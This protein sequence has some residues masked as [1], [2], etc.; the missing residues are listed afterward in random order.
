MLWSIHIC[1]NKVS[2]HQ[3]HLSES[4][5]QVSTHRS[6]VSFWSYPLTRYWF[7]NDRKLKFNFFKRNSYEIC[8]VYVPHFQ[9]DLRGENSVSCYRQGRVGTSYM[10]IITY[11]NIPIIIVLYTTPYIPLINTIYSYTS[12]Y[13]PIHTIYPYYTPY[14]PIQ[15]HIP[16]YTSIQ[17]HIPLYTPIQH[18]IPLYT[19]YTT[20]YTPI[21][22]YTSP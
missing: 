20:P 15:Q 4:R 1:Q 6:Q 18:H 13:T 12:P 17:Q 16:L 19:P 22:P 5:A 14:T 10:I 11:P 2:A 3:Y 7:S 8:Y 21:Y 9:T